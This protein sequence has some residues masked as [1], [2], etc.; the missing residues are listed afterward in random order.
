MELNILKRFLDESFFMDEAQAGRYIKL[1]AQQAK[2]GRITKSSFFKTCKEDDY[3]IIEEFKL[4]DGK[5]YHEELDREIEK[6]R[7]YS[8]SRRSNRL[9]QKVRPRMESPVKEKAIRD[10]QTSNTKIRKVIAPDLEEV[11]MFVVETGLNVDP[12]EFWSHYVKNGW[13][14]DKGNPVRQ[15]K[16][17]IKRWEKENTYNWKG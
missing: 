9:T 8:E 14:D 10:I 5:Y 7:R 6:A 17:E 3:H 15:W 4:V 12:R 2:Y 11:R 1:L 16:S 13:I